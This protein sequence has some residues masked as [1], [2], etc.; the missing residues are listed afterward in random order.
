MIQHNVLGKKLKRSLIKWHKHISS[1]MTGLFVSG[2]T[3]VGDSKVH[4]PVCRALTMNILPVK[5]HTNVGKVVMKALPKDDT[6][7]GKEK[8][9]THCQTK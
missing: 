3:A 6:S 5:A 2:G 1:G 8:A 7:T 9:F 4:D